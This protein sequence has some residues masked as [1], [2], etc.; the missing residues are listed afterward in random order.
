M[1]RVGLRIVQTLKIITI[2]EFILSQLKL[3]FKPWY[4]KVLGVSRIFDL[5]QII[6]KG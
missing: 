2:P 5:L 3:S 4:F 1:L 6:V